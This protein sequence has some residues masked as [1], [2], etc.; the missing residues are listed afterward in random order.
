[1]ADTFKCWI[2]ADGICLLCLG[3]EHDNFYTLP[4]EIVRLGPWR[5]GHSGK[6]EGLRLHFQLLLKEQGFV[7]LR[8]A[9]TLDNKQSAR[10]LQ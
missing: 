8:D 1:M 10:G 7:V 5:G 3:D 2:S 6:I 4:R 9:L